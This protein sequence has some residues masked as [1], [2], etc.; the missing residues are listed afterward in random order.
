MGFRVAL[1][2]PS[3][4]RVVSLSDPEWA[5][6]EYE[7][8]RDCFGD[9]EMLWRIVVISFKLT[10]YHIGGQQ[11]AILCLYKYAK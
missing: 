2:S 4:R 3:P 10:G 7:F 8:R 5:P 6:G 11:D 1:Y 9:V